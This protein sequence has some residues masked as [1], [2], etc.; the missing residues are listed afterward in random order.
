MLLSAEDGAVRY[1]FKFWAT[2]LPSVK[3]WRKAFDWP[4]EGENFLVWVAVNATNT[5]P[6]PAEA[7]LVVERLGP[8]A[9]PPQEFAWRLKPSASAEAVIRSPFAAVE[10]AAA[11]D[12]EDPKVWLQRTVD[13][14]KGASGRRGAN[15]GPMPEGDRGPIGRPRLPVDRQRPRRVARR[16]GLL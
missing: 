8:K 3:D 14:W 15:R 2:P 1:D 5:G 10:D 9:S 11:F 13:Y 6:K 4:T 7:K 12:S 16:R